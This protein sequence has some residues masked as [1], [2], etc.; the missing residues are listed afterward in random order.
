MVTTFYALMAAV[1]ALFFLRRERIIP[2]IL[3]G[4][5]GA[6]LGTRLQYGLGVEW[7]GYL[8]SINAV[9]VYCWVQ[10]QRVAR[11]RSALD[12]QGAALDERVRA[13]RAECELLEGDCREM[14]QELE[15]RRGLYELTRRLAPI[16]RMDALQAEIENGLRTFFNFG[17]AWMLMTLGDDKDV[18][19]DLR[20][21]GNFATADELVDPTLLDKMLA[22]REILYMPHE[23]FSD[24]DNALPQGT[25]SFMAIP[26][27]FKGAPA[28]FILVYNLRPVDAS[29]LKSHEECFEVIASLKSQFT[30]ALNKAL[31]YEE[32]EHMSRLDPL[33]EINKRWYF[34]QRLQEEMERCSRKHSQLSILMVDIDHFKK[35][36][37]NFGHL[38]GDLALKRTAGL[39]KKNLRNIDLCCRYGGEEFILALPDTSKMAARQVAERIRREVANSQLDVKGEK[40]TITVSLGVATYPEDG[41]AAADVIQKADDMLYRAKGTGRNRTC[42]CESAPA[43]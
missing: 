18:A 35:F 4:F 9:G 39:L 36:N 17:S 20:N 43:T 21:P 32:I 37:D 7:L 24:D 31:L 23:V 42:V 10:S 30:I 25:D 29:R 40:V 15:E 38:V 2:A 34:S 22:V 13:V 5:D 26:L 1:L 12:T 14:A 41:A 3:V 27:E 19:Y 11:G 8:V 33:T 6:M 28:A 16:M